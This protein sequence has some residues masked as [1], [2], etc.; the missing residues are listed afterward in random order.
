MLQN[1]ARKKDASQLGVTARIT[2]EYPQLT[3][4]MKKFADFVLEDPLEVASLS[5][6]SAVSVVGVSVA[7]A[8]RFVT[9]I[10]YGGYSEFRSDLFQSFREGNAADEN[11]R[12]SSLQFD[13]VHDVFSSE[14]KAVSQNIVS[15]L[16]HI[17][18]EDIDQA[19]DRIIKARNIYVVGT[20]VSAHLAALLAIGLEHFR[21]NVFSSAGAHGAVGA[22]Q[23]LLRYD[24]DDLV[25]AIAFPRYYRDTIELVR[26]VSERRVPVLGI[27]DNLRSPLASVADQI[28]LLNSKRLTTG[29]TSDST[30]LA[31]IEA[32]VAAVAYRLPDAPENEL[33]FSEFTLPW[34]S[35]A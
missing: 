19:V 14:L 18:A 15:S 35:R 13:S 7:T 11:I 16:R 2:A 3:A 31:F 27:T 33:A 26:F 20:N 12:K 30:I 21:G 28:L 10:G 25:I 4:S 29:Q 22:A 24:E 1:D 23:Q 5:I 32:L 8:H 6:H 17:G 9:K 34:Y